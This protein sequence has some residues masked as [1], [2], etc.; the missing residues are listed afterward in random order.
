MVIKIANVGWPTRESRELPSPDDSGSEPAS[1]CAVSVLKSIRW[2]HFLGSLRN[3]VSQKAL[4]SIVYCIKYRRM[5]F[6]WDCGSWGIIGNWLNH[7]HNSLKMH[8]KFPAFKK[9]HKKKKNYFLVITTY[10]I[11]SQDDL[12]FSSFLFF[13]HSHVD[14]QGVSSSSY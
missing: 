4:C 11:F 5:G 12:P 9:G 2:N 6:C 8:I 10:F 1:V 7:N 14:C 13:L 3:L